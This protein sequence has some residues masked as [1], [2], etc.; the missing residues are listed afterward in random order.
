[1]LGCHNMTAQGGWFLSIPLSP[2]PQ[3]GWGSCPTIGNSSA[4]LNSHS[5]SQSQGCNVQTFHSGPH[6]S[7]LPSRSAFLDPYHD[8]CVYSKSQLSSHLPGNL[9]LSSFYTHLPGQVPAGLSEYGVERC[10]CPGSILR[11]GPLNS[12]SRVER[13]GGKK[14]RRLQVHGGRASEYAGRLFAEWCMGS[15]LKDAR[16]F[17]RQRNKGKAF[18]EEGFFAFISPCTMRK[19][20]DVHRD[21]LWMWKQLTCCVECRLVPPW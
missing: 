15:V 3:C 1:M 21:S 9:W 11:L 7:Q 16:R 6:F 18:N 5:L 13:V 2:G 12:P 8:F 17:S 10:L 4:N 14:S 19:H 20:T